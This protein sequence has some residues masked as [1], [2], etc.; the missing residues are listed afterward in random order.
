MSKRG[1]ILTSF[2]LLLVFLT[3]FAFATNYALLIGVGQFTDKGISPLKY[4]L[5]DVDGM[6]S[7]LVNSGLV[8][9]SNVTILKNPTYG[10]A[11][12]A[13][14]NIQNTLNKDDTLYFFYSG[15]GVTY[16]GQAYFLVSNTLLGTIEYTAISQSMI[17]NLF[18][19]KASRVIVL[20][21]AYHSG[22]VGNTKGVTLN[23]SKVIEQSAQSV[24]K[25]QGKVLIISTSGEQVTQEDN[26]TK[27]GVFT[28]YIVK[29]LKN[30][31]SYKTLSNIFSGIKEGIIVYT[32]NTQTPQ[33]FRGTESKVMKMPLKSKAEEIM[34]IISQG[35]ANGFF[36]LN[37][38]MYQKAMNVLTEIENGESISREDHELYEML[39]ECYIEHNF[40]I[41]SYGINEMPPKVIQFKMKS[42]SF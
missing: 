7:T 2:T 32:H 5:N 22:K 36:P 16:K 10:Q 41:L 17:N 9:V 23:L 8:K 3:F 33:A 11:I 12:S 38:L 14:L 25:G 40:G 29:A 1:Y 39:E 27:M 31:K 19:S 15:R 18:K 6:Y 35:S 4:T 21:D 28:S 13:I 30:V 26:N 20:L 34:K 42:F 24:V 37:A